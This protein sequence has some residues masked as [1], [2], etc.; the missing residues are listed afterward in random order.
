MHGVCGQWSTVEEAPHSSVGD[1]LQNT[2]LFPTNTT[3]LG[4]VHYCLFEKKR[5][6]WEGRLCVYT[7]V[8]AQSVLEDCRSC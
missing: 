3:R 6:E 1:E 8:Y 4:T 2:L 7:L 5:G